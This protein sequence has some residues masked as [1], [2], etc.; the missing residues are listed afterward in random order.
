MG[1]QSHRVMYTHTRRLHPGVSSFSFAAAFRSVE[2][3]KVASARPIPFAIL[4]DKRLDATARLSL[5][6][7]TNAYSQSFR[8]SRHIRDMPEAYGIICIA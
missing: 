4:V 6:L 1:F 5:A 2:Y 3:G 7:W 8:F